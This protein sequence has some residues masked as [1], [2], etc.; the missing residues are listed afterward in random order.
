MNK[1]HNGVTVAVG[2][3]WQKFDE[4]DSIQ[5][6]SQKKKGNPSKEKIPRNGYEVLYD[7]FWQSLRDVLKQR[8]DGIKKSKGVDITV[9]RLR[10][11][12]GKLVWGSILE[13]IKNAD[14]LVFDISQ[15]PQEMPREECD[16]SSVI[17]GFNSNVLVE[18][19]V[20]LGMNKRV[21]L[22]C[23]K[24]LFEE[25]PSD[26]KGFLWT[27]YTGSI[28]KENFTRTFCDARGFQN[29]FMGMLRDTIKEKS[30]D[31]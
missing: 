30:S 8:A 11:S 13:N 23:P 17:K 27:L 4:D 16:I 22:L 20:A 15:P 3:G 12:H 2:Y 10:A 1:E 9:K 5:V 6:D 19:G 7:Q 21:L 24:H 26:L 14:I 31:I 29:A 28:S 18:V 25:V